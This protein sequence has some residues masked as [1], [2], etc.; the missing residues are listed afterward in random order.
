[1]KEM[2]YKLKFK[3][4]DNLLTD[5]M[6]TTEILFD[7]VKKI[8]FSSIG[9]SYTRSFVETEYRL[10]KKSENSWSYW[11]WIGGLNLTHND[12]DDYG[13]DDL[14]KFREQLTKYLEA[15][16]LTDFTI[17]ERGFTGSGEG[18]V[19]NGYIVFAIQ[20]YSNKIV[21]DKILEFYRKEKQIQNEN[22]SGDWM[23]IDYHGES[24]RIYR[25]RLELD[26]LEVELVN[27]SASPEYSIPFTYK[28]LRFLDGL[29]LKLS[30][31]QMSQT[32]QNMDDWFYN[33]VLKAQDGNIEDVIHKFMD[34]NGFERF[35]TTIDDD[36]ILFFRAKDSENDSLVP[37]FTIY[38]ETKT[39]SKEWIDYITHVN[40]V[41]ESY[42]EFT[43]NELRFF[44]G[45]GFEIESSQAYYLE[46]Q[47]GDWFNKAQDAANEELMDKLTKQILA[48]G[49]EKNGTERSELTFVKDHPEF[50]HDYYLLAFDIFDNTVQKYYVEY[51]T[52]PTHSHSHSQS[53]FTF[54]ALTKE[55]LKI[56]DS[57][58]F[59]L[60]EQQIEYGPTQTVSDWFHKAEDKDIRDA[61]VD[62]L[63]G[64]GWMLQAEG[65]HAYRFF[66][67]E[68]YKER[69]N[70]GMVIEM[71]LARMTVEKRY[72][73][74]IEETQ[75]IHSEYASFTNNELQILESLGFDF[76][77][78]QKKFGPKQS[79]NDWFWGLRKNEK[80]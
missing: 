70:D 35:N 34:Y 45:I 68:D 11:F 66:L 23:N 16:G 30:R 48:L 49:Y 33:E 69:P 3:A 65:E 38:L 24:G 13:S 20:K 46:T 43:N 51:L 39:V 12:I 64:K 54:Y 7:I 57:F 76:S 25:L 36:N 63:E 28:E 37:V 22:T 41:M 79:M 2:K 29:G 53:Q 18:F 75:S 52:E 19:S 77:P 4:E 9:K 55:E 27:Y 80:I 56:A 72:E 40:S 58:G 14:A 26:E 47:T 59:E 73:S 32:K 78:E 42:A 31:K 71:D 50:E 67:P 60:G 74:F 10:K 17:E 6:L 44:D 15:K 8:W 61:I 1:V 21:R 5:D 62:V